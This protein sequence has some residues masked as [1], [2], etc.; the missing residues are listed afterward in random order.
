MQYLEVN[1]YVVVVAGNFFIYNY[2]KFNALLRIVKNSLRNQLATTVHHSTGQ[3]VVCWDA[4]FRFMSIDPVMNA[5]TAHPRPA[6]I[7][8]VVSNISKIEL[9][10][11]PH[12]TGRECDILCSF[13]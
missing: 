1:Q 9:D 3:L 4:I 13:N 12:I 6:C 7:Y 10:T 2:E 5:F 11:A 8:S